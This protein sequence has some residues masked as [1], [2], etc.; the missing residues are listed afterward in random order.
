VSYHCNRS[1]ILSKPLRAWGGVWDYGAVWKR[2]WETQ[3][4]NISVG[5][6]QLHWI[7]GANSMEEA[8]EQVQ[9]FKLDG[10][11]QRLTQPLLMQGATLQHPGWGGSDIG[12]LPVSGAFAR[13]EPR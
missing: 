11:M 3:T 13:I 10:M 9:Q 4:K 2:P 12:F 8:L 7:M 1:R 5:F 6:F